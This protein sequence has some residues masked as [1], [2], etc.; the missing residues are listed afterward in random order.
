MIPKIR[1]IIVDDE[2][3]GVESLSHIL[4]ATC[5]EVTLIGTAQTLAGAE[6]LLRAQQPDL[7]FLDVQLGTQTVFQLLDRL[8]DISFEIIF[9]SAHDH[10]ITAIKFM[11]IDY[12]LKPIDIKALREAVNRAVYNRKNRNFYQHAQE[13]LTSLQTGT[14]ADA[15]IAVPTQDGYEFVFTQNIL[16]CTADRSYTILHL[17]DGYQLLA[18][19][20]LKHYEELLEESRF[21]RIHN[22][23]LVNSRHIKSISRSGGGY[24]VMND[25]Q[26]LPISKS[27][28]EQ[29]L[30]MLKLK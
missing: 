20:I 4:E 2:R 25:N 6:Q 22:S 7:V 19:Q 15:K 12:L 18:S 11:A 14:P 28:K 30:T 3:Q 8:D 9:V 16:Y 26:Q 1:S 29:L 17:Q 10:A 24:V 21:I 23:H 27:R 5:P 13:L